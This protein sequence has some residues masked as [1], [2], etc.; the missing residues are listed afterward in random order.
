M[1][2]QSGIAPIDMEAERPP[3]R[4][5]WRDAFAYILRDRL[6]IFAISVLARRHG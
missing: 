5:F 2:R 3:S 1:T 4:S 6:T